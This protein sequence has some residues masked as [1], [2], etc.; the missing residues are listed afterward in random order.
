MRHE[1]CGDNYSQEQVRSLYYI[2]HVFE[3]C[4]RPSDNSEMQPK[5]RREPRAAVALP[6]DARA[7]GRHILTPPAPFFAAARTSHPQ[8]ARARHRAAKHRRAPTSRHREGLLIRRIWRLL[9][10]HSVTAAP[11]GACTVTFSYSI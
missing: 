8:Y 10:A 2:Y 9:Y 6:S 3:M 4:V 11:A 1:F 5:K 7:S